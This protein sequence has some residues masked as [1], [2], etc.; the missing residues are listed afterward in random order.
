MP[1]DPARPRAV[2]LQP[3]NGGLSV[4]RALVRRHVP[5]ELL[6]T[7]HDSH[8]VATRGAVGKVLPDFDDPD[9]WLTALRS[10][11]ARG[12]AVVLC[13]SDEA[14][15]FLA[16]HRDDLPAAL[17]FFERCDDVHLPLMD[18]TTS[19]ELCVAA[20]VRAPATF[21]V[22][23]A[24]DLEHAAGRAVYP[25][26]VKPVLSHRWRPVFGDDRVLLADDAGELRAHCEKA[27][28]AGLEVIVSEYVPGG[29]DCMEEAILVRAAD[30]TFPMQFGCHKL[31]QWPRGF[32]ASSLCESDPLE[33]SLA[34]A[35]TLLTHTG[36]VGV[37]GVEVKRHATTG[38][39]YFIEVNVR[40]PTQF[41]LGDACGADA[42]WRT[43]ATLA[44]IDLEAAPRG[45]DGVKLVFPELELARLRR[46]ARGER[47]DGDPATW[48]EWL[49][50]YRGTRT[51][52]VL[53]PRDPG[54]LLRIVRA[55]LG[56][57][58][59][60]LLRLRGGT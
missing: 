54:P 2:I 13:G 24:D 17:H 55:A 4:A 57:R 37:A 19:Y 22:A 30:G 23:S 43:Y 33:E 60:R 38:D 31:R 58:A 41:G 11:A 35:R 9:A 47:G 7:S 56:R 34:M 5:V 32:G 53:D 29:D 25:S 52:G 18:K 1:S 39:R 21:P 51:A 6:A 20:G 28:G 16:S 46:F 42:S 59:K 36:Y 14:S 27:L 3:S 8:T 40:I 45:R 10:C 44:D 50:T 49:R 48:R 12:P 15:A 26:V